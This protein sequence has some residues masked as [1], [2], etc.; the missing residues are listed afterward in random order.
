MLGKD[1]NTNRLCLSLASSANQDQPST[2]VAQAG[3]QQSFVVLPAKLLSALAWNPVGHMY[4]LHALAFSLILK[5]INPEKYW[6]HLAVL[7]PLHR[8]SLG[9]PYNVCK[10]GIRFGGPSVETPTRPCEEHP[11]EDSRLGSHGR[12]VIHIH[13]GWSSTKFE[14]DFGLSGVFLSTPLPSSFGITT[15]AHPPHRIC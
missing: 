5:N 1:I 6:E 10:E 4:V 13:Q 14:L 9:H 15:A 8:G 2:A 11:K 12:V 7:S 3:S